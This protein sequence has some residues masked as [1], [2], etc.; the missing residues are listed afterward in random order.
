MERP[1]H[2]ANGQPIYYDANGQ[3]VAPPAVVPPVVG[4]PGRKTK[5]KIDDR[6]L[7][8]KKRVLIPAALLLLFI[9]LAAS[10]GGGDGDGD[11]AST[12]SGASVESSESESR[13][14]VDP[15]A[16]VAEGE[17][18]TDAQW[19]ARADEL[20]DTGRAEDWSGTVLDVREQVLGDDYYAELE[21]SVDGLRFNVDLPQDEALA[22]SKGDTITVS[23]NIK[24]ATR[25]I[26]TYRIELE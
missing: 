13:T 7:W 21:S 25:A 14:A 17:A 8:K 19:E 18:M 16:L 6:P 11:R 10:S 24:A 3:P 22:L 15:A 9:G 2:D 20:V 26:G 23:G 12:D 1:T 5:I 4:K